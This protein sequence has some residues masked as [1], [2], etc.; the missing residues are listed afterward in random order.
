[1]RREHNLNL[2]Y[3]WQQMFRIPDDTHYFV[4]IFCDIETECSDIIGKLID[5]NSSY[6]GGALKHQTCN[7]SVRC[8]RIRVFVEV[9]FICNE[10]LMVIVVETTTEF[11]RLDKPVHSIPCV[12]S[13][14]SLTALCQNWTPIP[15]KES[16]P[17]QCS[18]VI[19][20][21]SDGK[22]T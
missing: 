18:H 7:I 17:S 13:W 5:F 6:R 11:P 4:I 9:K 20:K 3:I 21:I 16:V 15:S 8:R 22:D 2:W 14:E 19:K 1:M 12:S 10:L